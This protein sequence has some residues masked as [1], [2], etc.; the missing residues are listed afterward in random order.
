MLTCG[1][2]A[3]AIHAGQVTHR[4]WRKAPTQTTGAGIWFDL[5]MSPGD[6]T[7]NYYAASPLVSQAMSRSANGGLDHGAD[8]PG[9]QKLLHEV[10]VGC[11]LAGGARA[12]YRLLDYL[13]FYPFVEQA[14]EQAL[15]QGDALPRY[16][17]GAGVKIMPVL[18]APQG[19]GSSF[20]CTYTNSDGVG[21]RVTPTVTCNTQAVNGTLVTSATATANASGPFVPLQSGDRGLRQ[22]DGVTFTTPDVGLLALVLVRPMGPSLGLYETTA[23][24]EVNFLRDFG[25]LPRIEPDAY[26]NWIVL[27]SGTLASAAIMGNISTAW[28]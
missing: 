4:S 19:G 11:T 2:L 3:A 26:L 8:P 21:G 5:S 12:Q 24:N 18:V 1:Q 14:G 28:V 7:P 10:S 22:I 6:P 9:G 17:D 16:T 25:F 15:V 23:P 27:P 20:F 13:L